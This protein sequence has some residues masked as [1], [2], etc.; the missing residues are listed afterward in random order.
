MLDNPKYIKFI[1]YSFSRMYTLIH[2]VSDSILKFV[3]ETRHFYQSYVYPTLTSSLRVSGENPE[4]VIEDH[5]IEF[6]KQLTTLIVQKIP[7]MINIVDGKKNDREYL[8][9]NLDKILKKIYDDFR[10]FCLQPIVFHSESADKMTV[11]IIV[12]RKLIEEVNKNL[13]TNRL[14]LA[15]YHDSIAVTLDRLREHNEGVEK[16]I[17]DINELVYE[18]RKYNKIKN[19]G[20]MFQKLKL[21]KPDYSLE[22]LNHMINNI[23]IESFMFIIR[24]YKQLKQGI[25]FFE[26]DFNNVLNDNYRHYAIADGEYGVGKLPRII[27]LNEEREQYD[28]LEVQKSLNMDIFK[29]NKSWK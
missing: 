19:K 9:Y 28:F 7:R 10:V 21:R 25:Y 6:E 13:M 17:S 2:G 27:R 26:F 29:V 8:F 18:V 15:E 23:K 24:L 12:Y 11:K 3:N 22:Q 20:T 16:Q 14:T 5:L 4:I 1:D